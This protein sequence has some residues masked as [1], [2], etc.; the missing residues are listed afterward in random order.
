M[1]IAIT[2][3]KG[4]LGTA[5]QQELAV[6]EIL[7]LDLPEHDITDPTAIIN[8]VV[9]FRPDVVI[10]GAAMTNVDGC[11]KDPEL[12]FRVNT[13]ATQNIALACGR[14]GAAGGTTETT[15]A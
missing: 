11:E 1:R 8:A 15:R 12:A 5:L 2:G 7:G 14:C 4:Q 6:H 13:L 3:H 10:H 9:Q